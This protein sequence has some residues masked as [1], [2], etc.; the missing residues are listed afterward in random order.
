MLLAVAAA[1]ALVYPRPDPVVAEHPITRAGD[2]LVRV[3]FSDLPGYRDDDT[4]AAFRTF[5]R[6]CEKG[7]QDGALA[8]I[9]LTALALEKAPDQNADAIAGF[10]TE[11]FRPYRIEPADGEGLVTAYYEPVVEG[12]REKSDRF[13]TPLYALPKDFVRVTAD[14]RPEGW[15]EEL[16][17][18]R[19]TDAG[20]VPAP[21]RAEIDNGALNGFAE[22][23]VYVVNAIEAF[24]IHIQGSTRIALPDGSTVRIGFAGKN[25][26]PYSSV[27]KAMQAKGIV[28][29]GGFS[30]DAMRAF[31]LE[32]M[33]RGREL[34]QENRSY[35]F[36]REIRDLAPELGPVGGEGVPLTTGRS[37]AVDTKFHQYGTPIFIDSVP[38]IGPET[39]GFR[40]PG[41]FQRLMIAQDTGS[42]I[43]GPARADLFWGTGKEAGSMAGG[44]KADGTFYVLLPKR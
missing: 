3:G 19:M 21:T 14:N 40:A 28:P 24:Y 15:D 35:I 41:A 29:P 10:F 27:G 39:G 11:Y 6:S 7:G 16:S 8:R 36:F 12:A 25:G 38:Q 20:L 43:G 23:L 4:T 17:W 42:A 9:C 2:T 5:V 26:H 32:D 30:M 1:L 22:P 18:G 31:F 34:M 13:T 33:D 44:I 37:I